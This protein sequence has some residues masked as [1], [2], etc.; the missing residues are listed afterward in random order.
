MKLSDFL[1]AQGRARPAPTRP[2]AF[3]VLGVDG[4]MN[5]RVGDASAELAFVPEAPRQE[6]LRDA[7]RAI[8]DHYGDQP[9]PEDRRDDEGKYH[10]L[11]R[12]LRDRDDVRQPFADSVKE[13]KNAL[14]L[15]EASRLW[16]E[17]NQFV[18]EE[19]PDLV[20]AETFE[21]LVEEAKNHFLGDLVCSFGFDVVRRSMFG[22]LARLKKLPTPT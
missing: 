8:R 19:F 5:G 17:Y 14:V 4:Q 3:K 6:A 1:N 21:K 16:R 7:E 18:D 12:A 13:L 10:V 2:I 11:F 20:D 22:L 15:P 9:I